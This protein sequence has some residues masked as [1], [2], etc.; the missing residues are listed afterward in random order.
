MGIRFPPPVETNLL[1][2]SPTPIS[3]PSGPTH[4]LF[5]GPPA[6]SKLLAEDRPENLSP[7]EDIRKLKSGIK[8]TGAG[9]QKIDKKKNL[10]PGQAS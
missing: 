8:Q 3:P 7:A 6:E 4:W 9:L 1:Q 10:K 5:Q 2:T